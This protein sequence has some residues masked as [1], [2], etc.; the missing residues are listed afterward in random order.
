MWIGTCLVRVPLTSRFHATN[1]PSCTRA[2]ACSHCTSYMSRPSLEWSPPR[3]SF[4]SRKLPGQMRLGFWHCSNW[5]TENPMKWVTWN[6]EFRWIYTHLVRSGVIV[7]KRETCLKIVK[8]LQH[9]C[10]FVHFFGRPQPGGLYCFVKFTTWAFEWGSIPGRFEIWGL[11]ILMPEIIWQKAFGNLDGK[12][13]HRDS[14]AK[15]NCSSR[16]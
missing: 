11:S 2:I 7:S 4:P 15:P 8:V 5:P 6:G 14:T 12:N 16:T 13:I 9:F 10:L 1:C 3:P